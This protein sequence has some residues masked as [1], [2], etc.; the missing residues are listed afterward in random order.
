M[1]PEAVEKK[2]SGGS[3]GVAQ[4]LW[5]P[6][7]F[8]REMLGW[9]RSVE[10]P[11]FDIKETDGAYVCK[12]KLTLPDQA[13]VTRMKAKLDNGELTVVVQKAAAAKPEPEPAPPRTRQ[14]KGNGR[15]SAARTPRRGARSRS[16]RG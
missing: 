7:W 1:E 12:L 15:G 4:T 14:A 10:A 16:R 13:D 11:S 2:Q 5:D 3:P 6:F 8:M 9:G